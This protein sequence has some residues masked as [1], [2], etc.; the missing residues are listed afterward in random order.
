MTMHKTSTI[1]FSLTCTFALTAAVATESKT[2]ASDTPTTVRPDPCAEPKRDGKK[3]ADKKSTA[4]AA[5]S[6]KTN[7]PAKLR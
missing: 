2:G 5:P 1:L 7:E 6:S 3:S 4:P